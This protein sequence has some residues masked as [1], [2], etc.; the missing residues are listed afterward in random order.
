MVDAYVL[1]PA[2]ILWVL[3]PTYIANAAATF[4]RGWGAPMDLGRT[5]PGDGRRILGPSKSWSGFLVG[6]LFALPFGFLEE[7]LWLIAPTNLR[8]VPAFGPSLAGAIPVILLLTVGGLAGDALGSFVKRR[9]DRP[10]GSRSFG[11]DQLPFVAVPVL[12]GLALFPSVFGP[13]FL[14]FVALLWVLFFTFGLHIGF[15]W[16]GYLLGTKKVPW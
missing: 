2:Q 3:L 9:L 13:T 15:N 1:L 8:V 7:Y 10:S 4:T 6:V 12:V 5:W 16:L 14:S 11:L